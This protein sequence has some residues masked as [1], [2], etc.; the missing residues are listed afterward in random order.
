M[1]LWLCWV[2]VAVFRLSLVAVSGISFPAAV[3][4]LLLLQSMGS[5]ICELSS[6][7]AWVTLPQFMGSSWTGVAPMSP[8]LAGGFFPTRPPGKSH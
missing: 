2:F 7:G 8:A 3:H 4:R 5:R 1:Y 6:C